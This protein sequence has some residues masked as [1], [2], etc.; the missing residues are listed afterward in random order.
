M[1]KHCKR[2]SIVNFEEKYLAQFTNFQVNSEL[3]QAVMTA[4]SVQVSPEEIKELK[5]LFISLD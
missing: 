5:D 2:K 4:I 3:E 1:K